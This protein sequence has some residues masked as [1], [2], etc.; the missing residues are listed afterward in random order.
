VLDKAPGRRSDMNRLRAVPCTS[1]VT[2]QLRYEPPQVG[3]VHDILFG[4]MLTAGAR[5]R[6]VLSPPVRRGH[7]NSIAVRFV[8]KADIELMVKRA[9]PGS[10]TY[11][12]TS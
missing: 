4:R 1:S 3:A 8:P 5:G 9:I 11:K 12:V 10:M 2:V 7:R 6:F